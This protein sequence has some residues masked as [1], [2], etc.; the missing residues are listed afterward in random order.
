MTITVA[1]VY[2]GGGVLK[3]ERPL[4][5]KDQ[6]RVSVTIDATPEAAARAADNGASD[7]QA[8]DALRGV[9]KGAPSDMAER[10]DK[11]IYGGQGE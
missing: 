10:H 7:W 6:A 2:E 4:D 9:V 5:L 3:L 1:A 11:Y 8:I